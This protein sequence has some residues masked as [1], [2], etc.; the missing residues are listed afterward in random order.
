MMV[1]THGLVG[2]LFAALLAPF[3]PG[4]TLSLFAAGLVGGLFP[5][6]DMLFVH[7][8]TLHFP[9]VSTATAIA[10]G[11]ALAVTALQPVAVL[12][13]AVAASAAHCLLDTLGGGKEMRPWRETD[14]RAVYDHV[15]G[16][17]IAPR[18]VF[19]DGSLPDL[20]LSVALGA[21]AVVL[22]PAQFTLPVAALVGFAVL[23]TAIRRAITRWI[24][25]EY[26]TFPGYIQ[27]KL[28]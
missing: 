16:Q 6:A 1:F 3:F 21:T 14:D 18:R 9:V 7:R 26:T 4:S 22:L 19:Y 2:I 17:W 27:S 15:R 13:V 20:G 11:V 10:L 12:F 23:Y 5:D 24:P 8:R 25:E 28:Q